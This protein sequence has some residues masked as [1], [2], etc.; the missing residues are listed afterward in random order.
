MQPHASVLS[1]PGTRPPLWMVLG[2]HLASFAVCGVMAASGGVQWPLT[3]WLLAQGAL[4]LVLS[5]LAGLPWWWVFINSLFFNAI[6]ALHAAQL[7]PFVFLLMFGALLL[8]NGGAWVQRVPLFLSSN[9]ASDIVNSL[10]PCN[11]EF[12]FMD[13]G[14]GTGT[15]LT[16][17]ARSRPDGNF[18][19]VELAPLPYL[20][21]LLRT[22]FNG[23]V[24]VRW[25][26]FWVVDLAEYDVVY[27]YL[28]PA[29]MAALWEKARREMR[30][31]SLFIS[32]G[33]C[34][35]GVAPSQTIAV[36]DAVRSTL[37][38]WRM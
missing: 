11:R 16:H 19:G 8:I 4:A 15:L 23:V 33:F 12:R 17:L 14:C 26:D 21:S 18:V 1:G 24:N 30:P 29:P 5:L 22:M 3:T 6:Y 10:L 38:I 20:L 2:I 25:G 9:R 36:G 35:P 34:V 31:G 27:A 7:P 37:Y 32:N 28:S 13:L